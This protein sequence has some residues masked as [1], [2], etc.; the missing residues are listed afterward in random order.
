MIKFSGIKTRTVIYTIIPV[1]ISFCIIFTILFISLFNANQKAARSDFLNIVRKHTKIFENKISNVIEYLSFVTGIL[2]F[3][4]NEKHTDREALQRMLFNI[5]SNNP[6]I[7]GSSIY[8][9]PNMYDGRDADFIGTEYGTALSG[10]ISFYYYRDNGKTAYQPEAFENDEDFSFPYYIDAKTKNVPIYTDPVNIEIDDENIF[11]FVIVFPIRGANNEFIG[12][13]T[14]DIHLREIYAALK[15]E[16]VYETGS[17]IITNDNGRIIYS[18][19]YED[20]GKTREEAGLVRAVPPRPPSE[21]NI[22]QEEA[23]LNN[24]SNP[25]SEQSEILK[26]KSVFNNK[27]TLM[28]RETIYFPQLDSRYYFSVIAPF[29]EINAIGNKLLLIIVTISIIVLVMITSILYYIAGKMTKPLVEFTDVANFIAQ[30]NYHIRVNGAY[31]DEFAVLKETVNFMTDRI[32]ENMDETKKSLRILKNILDGIDALIYVTIPGTGEILFINEPMMK[33]FNLKGEEGIGE[34]CY[35]LF[36]NRDQMCDFCPCNKL[37]KNPDTQIVWEEFAA[38]LGRDIRHTDCYINWPGGKKVHMQYAFDVTD[39]K[40]ITEEKLIAQQEAQDLAHKKEQAEETSRMKSVFLASMSHEIRTPMHGI[41]GFSELA[42]DDNIPLKTRNY[43]SKIKTSAESLLLII[44]DILDVSKVEAGKI[45]IE[46]IPFNVNE[47]FKL[48]RVISSPKAQEKGLTMFCYAEPSVGRLLLGDP[49]RLRQILLNLLSN[50]VKF[51]NNGMVKLLSAISAKT[52]KT[53]TMHFEVKD[54]GVGM[55]EDQLS[56]VFQPFTQADEST[57]R[58]YGGTGLGLTISKNLVELMGGVLKAESTYGL[59]SRFSFELTFETIDITENNTLIRPT[60][61]INEKPIFAGEVLI[62]EDNTLNQMVIRDH[63]AKV[64]LNSVIAVN[65]RIGLELIKKRMDNN[66]KQFDLIFMDIHMPEMDGLETARK[67]IEMGLKTPII[68]LTANIMTNDKETY[69]KAGMPEC[70]PKPFIAH[71]LWTCLLKYLQPVSMSVINKVTDFAEE[72]DQRM[73]LITTFVKSNQTTIKDINDAYNTGDLKLAHRLAHTLKGVAGIIK[74]KKLSAAAQI[75][76]DSLANNKT[77]K[78][79]EQMKTME[80]ELQAAM[81]E[82]T[83]IVNEYKER[84]RIPYE[85]E[86]FDT[87]SAL[88]LLEKL[89]LLL[90][91]DNFDSL[92]LINDLRMIHGTEK[93]INQ[94]ENIKFKQARETLA[95]VR[96]EILT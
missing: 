66:E 85:N 5:F 69:I 79:K 26:I 35:K 59:G 22:T 13:I 61:Q 72:E 8:F 2:E 82:L 14:A 87:E 7:D 77:N 40:K 41:I 21:S 34:K 80:N 6:D 20:I 44:N 46:K 9:E 47:V 42:L 49:T 25:V 43:I 38:E 1:I 17:I 37:D 32:E 52:E 84:V 95:E 11:M 12:A 10:R 91:D 51:T 57:T 36:R 81:L 30:G 71:E 56:R 92:N 29:E 53:I 18:S 73:E 28:S 83:P 45:E 70:L 50:A 4:V 78:I 64:G 23:R 31:Q 33:A 75:V 94:V 88:R 62:C 55:T 65:G 3:Q 54:S 76:E 48:C 27:D 86:H 24:S 58:K 74:Q 90:E 16:K 39:V 96:K 15:A 93:L 68:A 67:I 63:L 19:R 89:D 60:V